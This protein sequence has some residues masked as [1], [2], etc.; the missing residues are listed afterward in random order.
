M[1]QTLDALEVSQWH[2][3][4]K[5]ETL[6]LL[7]MRDGVV[8]T[9]I[10]NNAIGM[11]QG[12]FHQKL[13][14]AVCHLKQLKPYT[15][16]SNAAEREVK[17]L[18]KEVGHKMLLSRAPKCLRNDWLELEANIRY[19]AAHEIHKLDRKKPKTVMSGET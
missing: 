15:T 5:H 12:K 2:P 17:E 10:C 18:K 6:S 3:E 8:P 1:P 19:N 14:E 9:C 4:V 13:K 11:V 7:F 16:W